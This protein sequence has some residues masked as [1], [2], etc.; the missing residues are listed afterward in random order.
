VK[1]YIA[2]GC[3][4]VSASFAC[5]GNNK[6]HLDSAKVFYEQALVAH[7]GN[8]F[9]TSLSLVNKWGKKE[10]YQDEEWVEFL[11][12][13]EREA[14]VRSRDKEARLNFQIGYNFDLNGYLYEA[15]GY[16]S[17]VDELIKGKTASEVPY[18]VDFHERMG[19]LYYTFKSYSL[20][21][22]EFSMLLQ[23][24]NTTVKLRINANNVIALIYRNTGQAD[25]SKIYF[26]KALS[27]A[28]KHNQQEW[29]GILS[30]NLGSYYFGCNDLPRAQ[31]L[32]ETDF[33]ISC[34][35]GQWES[36][37]SAVGLLAEI[38]MR[39]HRLDSAGQKLRQME[40]LMKE[41][42]HD[43]HTRLQFHKI[44]TLLY[45]AKGDYAAAYRNQ[46]QYLA[47][48]D[49]INEQG[50]LENFHNAEF[51]IRF[52]KKQTQIKL[53][54]ASRKRTEQLFQLT[55]AI[56]CC[57]LIGFAII[58]RQIILRKR[59]EKELLLVQK[60][61]V[62]DELRNTDEQMRL[63]LTN[64]REKNVLLNELQMKI[65]QFNNESV[66]KLSPEEQMI[67]ADRLQ[68]FKLL[69]EDDW[70][71]FRKLFT[72]LYPGFFDNFLKMSDTLSKA[73]LRLGALMRLNLS[74]TEIARV[75]GI[76]NDS[77]KRT[78]LRLRKKLQIDDHKELEELIRH[79]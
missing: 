54:D 36:A 38:D 10:F 67:L 78:H 22:K 28:E 62:E 14:R 6:I 70:D 25:S 50:N 19:L 69:T 61:R 2:I 7:K 21:K 31:R 23:E 53:L 55:M 13:C 60:L 74:T 35:T 65:E 4:L 27:L 20:A 43:M 32:V 49:S 52:Q 68:S 76:S 44:S 46:K 40:E 33:T 5:A 73:D 58:F 15:F 12:Y 1:I 75:L 11:K 34:R 29:I 71:E 17:R 8:R 47:Y 41:H 37:M 77:V 66:Y 63:I 30:G 24:E 42:Y 59:K 16:Y 39:F 48:L 45:E 57:V 26:E 18:Y 51:Q 79:L 64:L 3:L 72:K 9:A 56:I